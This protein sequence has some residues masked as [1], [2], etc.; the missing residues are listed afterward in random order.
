MSNSAKGN[1]SSR[2]MKL[3]SVLAVLITAHFLSGSAGAESTEAPE[4]PD[5]QRSAPQN[6][7]QRQ[8]PAPADGGVGRQ[9]GEGSQAQ[10]AQ[11]RLDSTASREWELER[12]TRK[13]SEDLEAQQGASF[14][15]Q[16]RFEER[17]R[18]VYKGEDLVGLSLV[19]ESIFS[20]DS[21]RINAVLDGT[22]TRMLIRSRGSIQFNQDSKRALRETLRQL[23]QKKAEYKRLREEQR[24]RAEELRQSE[25]ES[26]VSIGGQNTKQEQ[27]EERIAQLEV[28][29]ESG[30]FTMPPAS[31]EGGVPEMQEEEL[32]I[33]SEDIVAR[34]VEPIPYER[35]VQIYKAAAK[36]YGFAENWHVLAAVGYVESN[37]GEN[38]GPSS[39]GAIGPMQFL[40][41]T[42]TQYGVDGNRDGDAN[43]MDPED[44][45]PAAANYLK[46]G[47]APEDWYAA[48]YTYNHV[49]RYVREVLGVAEAYRQQAADEEIESYV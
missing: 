28:A 32:G 24:A 11:T 17:V 3:A 10:E 41:S 31:S 34:E 36:R 30:E 8:Q 20:G 7:A 49:G 14:E 18:A 37:H 43:I 2:A 22:T 29:D 4:A 13:L 46:L 1:M 38:M 21:A 9:D 26:Q 25:A 27:M 35:Y 33:A 45:I 47:G 16:A 44:A 6:Q 5:A 40:P 39:A 48:L 19:L 23:N 12:Q 15:S 42:W